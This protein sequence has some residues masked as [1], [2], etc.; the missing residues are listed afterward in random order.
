M[1]TY[2]LINSPQQLA[3]PSRTSSDVEI[4]S[5][6][7]GLAEVILPP[8]Y[9]RKNIEATEAARRQILK[10]KRDRRLEGGAKGAEIGG[11]FFAR[12]AG[13][14]THGDQVVSNFHYQQGSGSRSHASDAHQEAVVPLPGEAAPPGSHQHQQQAG[15]HAHPGDHHSKRPRFGYSTD[16]AAVQRF[17]QRAY[18]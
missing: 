3:G 14:M 7:T 11:A 16:Q 2:I 17:K 18:K 15:G 10:D 12:P 5:A 13:M 8:D 9:H 1:Y 6:G 4:V